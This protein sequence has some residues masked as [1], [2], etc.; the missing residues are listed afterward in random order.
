VA[1]KVCGAGFTIAAHAEEKSER[2]INK[3]KN[4][5]LNSMCFSPVGE[6]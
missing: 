4:E 3:N 6:L 1:G 2:A 5:F